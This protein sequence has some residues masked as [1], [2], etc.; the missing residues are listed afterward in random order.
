MPGWRRGAVLIVAVVG[1]TGCTSGGRS[2]ASDPTALSP[3]GPTWRL[4]SIDSQPVLAG[5][6]VTA[7]FTS[8]NR[9]SG[10]AGCNGYSGT[11]RAGAGRLSV[12]VMSS[13]LMACA[14]EAVMAQEGRYLSVL[15]VATSYT[16]DGGELRLGRSA[17]DAT[18]VF[19]SR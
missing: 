5:T 7:Q 17:A 2:L 3:V 13:T 10:S 11:A 9:V 12:G 15:Q 18:L 6:A 14:P 16:M 1:L 19:T 8:E 4:V